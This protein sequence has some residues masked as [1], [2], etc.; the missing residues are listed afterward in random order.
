MI[1]RKCRQKYLKIFLPSPSGASVMTS[2]DDLLPPWAFI[3]NTLIFI[4]LKYYTSCLY[5]P[6]CTYKQHTCK[7]KGIQEVNHY[8][9][10]SLRAFTFSPS[11]DQFLIVI[12][13]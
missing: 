2:R 10:I 9:I 1:E 5:N 11:V 13:V 8:T 3:G 4:F 7:K 6:T 12:D